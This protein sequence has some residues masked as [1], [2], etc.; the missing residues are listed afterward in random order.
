MRAS[1]MVMKKEVCKPL[2][3]APV[4]FFIQIL[5][6]ERSVALNHVCG[7]CGVCKEWM[8][9]KEKKKAAL[10]YERNR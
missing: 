2:R 10:K 6:K 7:M 1:V 8:S 3:C 5:N 4:V 9:S